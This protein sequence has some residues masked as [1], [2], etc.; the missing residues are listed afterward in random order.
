MQQPPGFTDST[1]PQ[2]VCKLHKALYGLKQAPRAWFQRLSSF[3]LRYGFIQ[4]RADSS[5]FI[6]WGNS[7]M[8][9][10]LLYVDDIVLTG[11]SPSSLL[12]FIRILGIQF[13]LTDLGQLNYFLGMEVTY[14]SECVHLTQN[15]YT[16]DLL[17]RS[18]L[19]ECKPCSTP[20]ASK[21]SLSRTTGLPLSDPSIYRQLVGTL[22]YLTLT[23]PDIAYAVQSVSQFMGSP[24][25]LHMEAVKRILRYLKGTLGHGLPLR[26]STASSILV[27]YSD[28]DWAGCPD[29]RRSTTGYCMFLGANL[30]SWSAKKQRTVS[31]SSAKAEYHALAYACAD[32]IWIQ[33]LLHELHFPLLRPV[34]LNCDNLS[35]TYMATN[36]VFYARTKHVALDYHFVRERVAS[37]SHRV[38]FIPS[39]DQL[40][41][42]FTKGLP[43]DRFTRLVSKL[44]SPPLPSLRGSVRQPPCS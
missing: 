42:V 41:D 37:G 11:S 31:R 25:D 29:T 44:V 12:D 24:T 1:R 16:L 35:A 4:S 30:I 20:M 2:H 9:I 40:A 6:F 10:L 22:Q 21:G 15:K 43:T 36:P 18:N 23:R 32:T 28:A 34:L 26:R 5:M 7:H 39:V 27:A 19:L 13:D 8:M 33:G 14:L 38:S 17:K 3:L